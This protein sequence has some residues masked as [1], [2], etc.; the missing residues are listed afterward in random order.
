MAPP[1]LGVWSY[2]WCTAAVIFF[3]TFALLLALFRHRKQVSTHTE[4]LL[5]KFNSS[6]KAWPHALLVNC[7]ITGKCFSSSMQGKDTTEF[8]LTAR[9]S[10]GVFRIAWSFYAATLGAWVIFTLP[11]YAYT[12]GESSCRPVSFTPVYA[13]MF[14]T[15]CPDVGLVK[16]HHILCASVSTAEF[17]SCLQASSAL[18]PTPFPVASQ[19]SSRVSWAS[20]SPGSCRMLCPSP[21]LCEW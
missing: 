20:T 7:V 21:T 18:W 3:G 16:S 15:E 10:S 1:S 2:V 9:R 17:S 8:F 11:S 19:F 12:Y 5:L 6:S 4:R 14:L 13:C